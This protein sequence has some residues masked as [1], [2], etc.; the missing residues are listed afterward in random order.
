MT[1]YLEELVTCERKSPCAFLEI[2]LEFR[3]FLVFHQVKEAEKQAMIEGIREN[4]VESAEF[5]IRKVNSS[6]IG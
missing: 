6:S 1:E 2:H 4:G 3:A 5:V